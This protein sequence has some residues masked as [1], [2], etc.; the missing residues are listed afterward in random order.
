MLND[1]DILNLLVQGERL[2]LEC[3]LC[4]NKL[5]N[6]LWDTYSAFAN[7]YGGYILLGIEE[8]RN[9]TD[10]SKRFTIHG[11]NNPDKLITDFWNLAND[12]NKVNMNLSKDDDVQII[13][14]EDK[15]IIAIY[16]P[17]ADYHLRPVYIN[18]NPLRGAYR[19]NHEGDY[20]CSDSELRMMFRDANELGNDDMVL[21]GYTMEDI[22]LPTLQAYRNHFKSG[23]PDHPFNNLS[24]EDFLHQFGCIGKD[25]QTGKEWL[26]MA[27]L[28]M[29]GKGL[30]IRTRFSNLRLDYIDKSHLVG[31]M[32]YSDRLTYD[33][34][35]ENNLFN[36]IMFVLPRLVR[37]LPHPFQME[38]LQRKDDT[39]QDKAVREAM[40]NAIIHADLMINGI[41]KVEKY[42][43]K[44]VFTNPG[45]L[46]LPV[47]Q[48]YA[49][50]ESRA[51]NLHIQTLFRMI[52]FG[53][54]IG[55]GFPLILSAWNEKHWLRPELIE[56]PE[57]LQVKLILN[58]ETEGMG[59]AEKLV[60]KL[61]ERGK[62]NGVNLTARQKD[63]VMR[64]ISTGGH[65]VLE[66][67]LENVIETSS[68]LAKY[69]QVNERTIRRDL[70]VL[71]TVGILRRVGP[72]KG[73]HWEIIAE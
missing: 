55:S 40:T 7:S 8:N 54:N 70:K 37:E 71:Q 14:I 41:L 5:P 59:A 60:E 36:F 49:G 38:G 46:K 12:T 51:R 33:G 22:D 10:P 19:R 32:R 27:G 3:K 6:S 58:I 31:E 73:G 34:T 1:V 44:F 42:D 67:V 63:I 72:D 53:E 57:L 26:T 64:L 47:E 25:T 39:L 20:H 4:A 11:V 29:F 30:P 17:R 68:S 61:E 45:L 18:N 69:Y 65:N 13:T 62:N 50:G 15:Q 9:E 66:N 2:T 52:G 23:S 28:F 35:W 24:N 56:Q 16:V 48:I 43:D 21:V